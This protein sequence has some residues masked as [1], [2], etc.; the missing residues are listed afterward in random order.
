[1]PTLETTLIQ[2]YSVTLRRLLTSNAPLDNEANYCGPG[3]GCSGEGAHPER[4]S[5]VPWYHH[6][7]N[8]PPDRKYKFVLNACQS[9]SWKPA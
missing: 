9:Q 3:R 8:L 6:K 1:M 7:R 2:A 5:H 4:T